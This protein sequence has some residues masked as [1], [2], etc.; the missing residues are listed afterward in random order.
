MDERQWGKIKDKVVDFLGDYVTAAAER[1]PEPKMETRDKDHGD[2]T[3]IDGAAIAIDIDPELRVVKA[4]PI[5]F[6][7]SH[8]TI[9]F[10]FDKVP[11]ACAGLITWM[12]NKREKEYMEAEEDDEAA[13]ALLNCANNCGRPVPFH[14]TA[15]VCKSEKASEIG[16]RISERMQEMRAPAVSKYGLTD[17]QERI[18]KSAERNYEDYIARK[19]KD[20]IEDGGD[21]PE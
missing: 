17:S 7:D 21:K 3:D 11:G 13:E 8:Y 18:K 4:N 12:W 5:G 19:G 9:A 1:K 6:S 20:K 14:Y 10:P 2:Y 16:D 15:Y